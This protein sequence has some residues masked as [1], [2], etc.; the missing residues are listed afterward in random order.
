MRINVTYFRTS[1]IRPHGCAPNEIDRW[2]LRA[3][4][5]TSPNQNKENVEKRSI[6]LEMLEIERD[7]EI[8]QWQEVRF[9]FERFL[10]KF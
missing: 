7:G 10:R 6:E 2:K 8:C 3:H 1:F 5:M 9:K 4:L